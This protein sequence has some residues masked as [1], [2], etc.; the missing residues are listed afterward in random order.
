MLLTRTDR[1]RLIAEAVRVDGFLVISDA[2]TRYGVSEMTIR[3]DAE[4]L[5]AQGVVRRVHGG[6]TPGAGDRSAMGGFSDRA[7]EDLAAKR[8]VAAVAATRIGPEDTIT[9]DAGT[10]CYAVAEA[11]PL[12]F[13]G[14]VITNSVPVLQHGLSLKGVSV[15]CLGGQLLA[16]SQALTGERGTKSMASLYADVAF[17][18]ASGLT[19]AGVFINRDLERPIKR[20]MLG[21]CDRSVVVLTALKMGRTDSVLLASLDEIDEVIISGAPSDSLR[22][23]AD[24]HDVVITVA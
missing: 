16:D 8:R 11:L 20:K 7:A 24:A 12:S 15:I 3:R 14:T 13:H 5:E 4:T 18:G 23:A 2:A 22:N 6:L 17:I 9:L 21:N 19:P 1:Q 10:T